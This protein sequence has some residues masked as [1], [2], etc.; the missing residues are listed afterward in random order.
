MAAEEEGGGLESTMNWTTVGLWAATAIGGFLI[1]AIYLQHSSGQQHVGGAGGLPRIGL[2]RI[3]A[4]LLL[5]AAGLALWIVYSIIDLSWTA[6]AA[7]VLLVVAIGLGGSMLL[8]KEQQRV[9]LLRGRAGDTTGGSAPADLPP[10]QQYPMWLHA[11]HGGLAIATLLLVL[12]NR[13]G[14]FG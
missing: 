4:H 11:G 5:A 14:V 9:L 13:V 12:L 2:P 10:E 1:L 7:L 6:W 3:G 8:T